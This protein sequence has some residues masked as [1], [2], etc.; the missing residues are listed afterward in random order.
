MAGWF[1]RSREQGGQAVA[2]NPSLSPPP[3]Q[4]H[5]P[6]SA[7]TQGIYKLRYLPPPPQNIFSLWN[8]GKT[9]AV[10]TLIFS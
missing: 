5:K 9:S 7:L 2:C 10:Y 3:H 8:L 6:T 1:A 4:S